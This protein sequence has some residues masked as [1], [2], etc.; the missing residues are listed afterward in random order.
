MTVEQTL[1]AAITHHQTGELKDAERL[2]R[3]I[4]TEEP[5]HPDANHNLGVL[6][7]QGE[8]ADRALP[9]LKIALETNPNQ[10]QFWVSYIDTLIHLGKLDAARNVLEQGYSRGLKG[11]GV[12]QLEERLNLHQKNQSGLA[13]VDVDSVIALYSQGQIQEALTVSETLIEEYPHESLLYNISGTCY[14]ALD[15]LDEAVNSFERALVINPDSAEVHSNLGVTLK[16]M[17]QLNEAVKSFEKALAI[18]PNYAEAYNNLGAAFQKF[19]Q[20][21]EAVKCYE[22]AL[23]IKP[24]YAKAHY[25]LGNTLNDLGQ[26]EAAVKRYELLLT[27]KPDDADVH[28]ILGNTLKELGQLDAAVKSYEKAIVINPL[29]A[30]A[31]SN[32]GVALSK[33]G[34]SASAIKKFEKA[35]AINSDYIEAYSN[36]GVVLKELGQLDEAVKCYKQALAIKPDYAEGHSNLGSLFQ[37]RGQL[38]AAAKS[39]EQALAINPNLAEAHNNFG[40]IFKELGQL[41]EAVKCYE[42]ALLINPD[43]AEAHSNLGVAYYLLGQLDAALK[44]YERVLTMNASYSRVWGELY[45][46]A[47]PLISLEMKKGSWFASFKKKLSFELLKGVDFALLTYRLNAFRPHMVKNAFHV[48]PPVIGEEINN[49]E[50]IHQLDDTVTIPERVIALIHFGRS[51]TG[52][53]HSLIDSHSEISTCPS[54]YFSEY[55]NPTT[56]KN[57]IATGWANLPECFVK[58]FSVLFDASTSVSVPSIDK[59]RINLGENEGMT[60]VGEG[61]DEVL[62]VNKD[63]FCAEL[64]QLMSG[65]S[66]LNPKIFFDLVHVA[67]EKVLNNNAGNKHTI[68]YHIHNPSPYAKLNFLRYNPDVRLVMMVREPVQ[69]CE[70]WVKKSFNVLDKYQVYS[71]II[72]MLFDVD[73]IVFRTQDTIGVRLEDLKAYPKETI[74]SLCDWMGVKEEACLYEMTAQG[75]KWWGDP[76]SLDYGKEAMSPFGDT[77][78]KRPVGSIFSEYDQFILRTLFYPFSVRFGYLEENLEGFKADLQTI[79]PLLNEPF[80]FEK[81]LAELSKDSLDIFLKSGPSLFFRA[82]LHNRWEVLEEFND[83]PHM[84]KPLTISVKK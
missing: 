4:L 81:K 63:A 53:L 62:V 11:D 34:Q 83:Y 42:Q 6:L 52:L 7:K 39:Y 12:D 31:Y 37:E 77:A 65:Y 40:V 8:Q 18:K 56:W 55:Y 13:Q 9:F 35:L 5:K 44:C 54:I 68:F 67:Y 32:L 58:Q 41:G 74:G 19:D 36:L 78:I 29:G 16:E 57:L 45:F 70:S 2:Y 82:S 43:Y 10:G 38:D 60:S 33:L 75:K 64:K 30:E 71:C 26:L 80:D 72:T 14:K 79:K 69:S 24:D 47:I 51:G 66:K 23:V 15:Q 48:L 3:S 20:L 25:N 73:Q 28:N 61:R 22:Q 59:P 46:L 84:L 50:V 17:G 1:Q 21:E 49:S 76:S 27:I